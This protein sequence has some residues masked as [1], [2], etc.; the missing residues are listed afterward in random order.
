[1]AQDRDKW[2]TFANAVIKLRVAQ[3][4]EGLASC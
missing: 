3:N 2:K 4:S 1:V